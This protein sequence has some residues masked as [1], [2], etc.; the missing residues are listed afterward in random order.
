M[1]DKIKEEDVQIGLECS[2][3]KDAIQQSAAPLLRAKAIEQKYVDAII[4]SVIKNGPYFVITKGIALAHARPECGV[5]FKA[6]SFS[7]VPKGV[8]FGSK[9]ND[10]VQ[11]IITLAA[12][13]PDCHLDVL[14]ELAE[15]LME[16]ERVNSLFTAKS[17]RQF[18]ERLKG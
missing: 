9:E 8:E 5:N 10:P 4:E 7:T 12:T 17:S 1:L 2:N 13:T 3:W 11:L 16:E 6:L 14:G 18:I 15:V